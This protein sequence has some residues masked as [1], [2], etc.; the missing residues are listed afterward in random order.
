MSVLY[1][2]HDL[3]VVADIADR[4]YVMYAGIIV[5]QG[6][7]DQI[8]AMPDIRIPRDFW[9]RFPACQNGARDFTVFRAR[10]EPGV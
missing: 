3:G 7:T 10:A 2:T 1:I 8:F 9:H 4:V 6:N 5:E